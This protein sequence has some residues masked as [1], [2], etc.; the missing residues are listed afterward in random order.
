[1]NTQQLTIISTSD[2]VTVIVYSDTRITVRVQPVVKQVVATTKDIIN[3][4]RGTHV[5]KA[6][7]MFKASLTDIDL[8]TNIDD[9]KHHLYLI[10]GAE[11]ADD[12]LY[13]AK[14]T[15]LPIVHNNLVIRDN[16][17]P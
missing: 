1:M 12:L 14:L 6:S 9:I 15:E 5:L 11:T 4:S 7:P 13:Q 16:Y 17:L 3:V 8:N 2:T 10:N